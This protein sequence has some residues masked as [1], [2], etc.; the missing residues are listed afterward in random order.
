MM[1][2]NIFIGRQPPPALYT[3]YV[4]G[5]RGGRP[6]P[7]QFSAQAGPHADSEYDDDDDDGADGARRHHHILSI[8]TL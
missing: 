8:G 7:R 3:Q 4:S 1:M 6:S 2:I 5:G